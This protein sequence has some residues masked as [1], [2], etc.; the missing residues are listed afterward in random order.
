MRVVLNATQVKP[1]SSGIGL[2]VFNWF[3]AL[4]KRDFFDYT[5]ILSHDSRTFPHS[6]KSFIYRMPHR[7]GSNISRLLFQTF[8]LGMRFCS[9]AV[10]LAPDTKFPLW[11]PHTCR[12]IPIVTDLA[13]Y[14]MPEAYQWSR[15]LLWRIQYK[16]LQ[17]RVKHW[18]AISQYTKE[19]MIH[20]LKIPPNNIDVVYCAA[21]P[22]IKRCDDVITAQSVRQK[23]QLPERYLL[24]VGNHNPRKNLSRLLEAFELFKEQ[25]ALSHNLV[26]VGEKGWKVDIASEAKRMNHSDDVVFLGY[27]ADEEMA[28]VYSMADLFVFT[29]LFEG[30]GIPVV[31][32]Q[33]C[34]VPVLTSNVSSLP[35]IAGEGALYVDPYKPEEICRGIRR[36]LED[37]VLAQHLVQ[38]GFDNARRFSWETSAEALEQIIR[39][40]MNCVDLG[41]S[42]PS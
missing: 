14:H 17:K 20:L 24:F 9:N 15:V 12:P 38:K 34:G 41:K 28:A 27:V 31:E 7:K 35:E 29:T 22:N 39:T 18:I 13:L 21:P 16:F 4:L 37:G 10:L 42:L 23:H 3:D 25:T 8:H 19:D 32:A 6:V 2:M 40:E 11:L 36:V 5:L 26:V 30:F 33:Q 1:N